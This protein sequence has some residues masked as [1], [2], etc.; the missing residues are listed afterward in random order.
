MIRP[1]DE[2]GHASHGWLDT[3]FSFSFAD[4]YDPRHMGFRS[5][6]VIND[7]RIAGGAGF[8]LHPHR[9][10]E[11]VTYMLDGA[12]AHRD[13]MGHVET[14]GEGEVQ[15][16]TAGSGIQHSEFN[17]LPD[18]ATRLLQIWMLPRQKGLTPSYEQRLFRDEDKRGKLLAIASGDG[19]GGSMKIEQD[20]AIYAS[21]LDSGE[22]A[23]LAL[24]PGRHAW[25]QVARGS[26]MLNG[27]E[28]KEGDGA[29]ISGET[30]LRFEGA[31]ASEFLVFDLA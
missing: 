6:R 13:S 26:V 25:V 12:L 17:P 8:P 24:E 5:L 20:A 3:R 16:M 7:D 21:R 9:D 23:S 15:R 2:R 14:I 4:Y 19:R 11:I 30:S 22:A 18:R 29:A 28:L 10:M 27:Q 31:A 1:S